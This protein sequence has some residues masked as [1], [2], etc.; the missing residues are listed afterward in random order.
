MHQ[1]RLRRPWQSRWDSGSAGNR[2]AHCSRKF[3]LPT[4]VDSSQSIVLQIR[5]IQSELLDISLNGNNLPFSAPDD[6]HVAI[7]V[8]D[9]L[10][11]FNEL[12]LTLKPHDAAGGPLQA[13][14]VF[15]ELAEVSL[16]IAE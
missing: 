12:V 5:L 11:A 10:A 2:L 3:H 16:Q 6:L 9:Q 14:P 7:P 13:P 8:E 4:N 1:I 15:E